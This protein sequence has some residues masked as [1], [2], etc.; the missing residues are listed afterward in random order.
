MIC[1][2][3]KGTTHKLLASLASFSFV[4]QVMYCDSSTAR[5]DVQQVIEL[6]KKQ[7]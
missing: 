4:E 2:G 6:L 1:T 5:T 7:I 3:P